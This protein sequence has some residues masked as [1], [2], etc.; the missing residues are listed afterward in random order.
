MGMSSYIG[1]PEDERGYWD[2]KEPEEDDR[3]PEECDVHYNVGWVDGVEAAAKIVD[4]NG[5]LN[6]A[7]QIRRLKRVAEDH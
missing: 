5:L 7:A 3:E 2:D 1:A 6:L 4:Q